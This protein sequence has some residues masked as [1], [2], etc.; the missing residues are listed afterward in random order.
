MV[1]KMK[2]RG[3]ILGAS[4]DSFSGIKIKQSKE[5]GTKSS[6]AT[7]CCFYGNMSEEF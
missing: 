5:W 6:K 4:I 1:S 2:I 3:A 7:D